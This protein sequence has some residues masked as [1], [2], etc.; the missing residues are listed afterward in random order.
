MTKN[1]KQTAVPKPQ[2]YRNAHPPSV[3]SG[4]VVGWGAKAGWWMNII[5]AAL[6]LLWPVGLRTA[7]LMAKETAPDWPDAPGV[8]ADLAAGFTIIAFVLWLLRSGTVGRALATV[9][10]VVWVLVNLGCYEFALVYE[11]ID[12]LRHA[13]Y[14]LDPTFFWGSAI[15]WK[16]L[17]LFIAS[18]AALGV[19]I[20]WPH[21]VVPT[22]RL[23][24]GLVGIALTGVA[25]S[26]SWSLQ[27]EVAPWRQHNLV[28]ANLATG[29][30][31]ADEHSAMMATLE[32][33]EAAAQ[34]FRRD[35]SGAPV[36]PH[37]AKPV[38]VLL[39]LLEGVSGGYLPSIA[40]RSGFD[41]DIPM[42]HLDTIAQQGISWTS[43]ITHEHQTNRGE[44]SILC[45]DYPKL[46][47][48]QAKMSEYILGSRRRCL[49]RILA[50]AGWHTAYL[51]SAPLAFMY[52]DQF[53]AQIGFEQVYG[54][55]WF[56]QAY[57]RNHWG[58][59]DRAFF[60]QGMYLVRT[61]NT[62]PKPWF[63]TLL[64]VGTHHP[65]IVPDDFKV[66]GEH[67]DDHTRALLWLDQAVGEFYA[68]LVAEGILDN[69]LVL[70]TSDESAGFQHGFSDTIRTLSGNWGI[71]I[72]HSPGAPAM[73]IDDLVVQSDLSLSVLDYLGLADG[74][75]SH[76]VGRSVFRRYQHPRSA[77]FANL[78]KNR[79]YGI[80]QNGVMSTCSQ[81][82]LTQCESFRSTKG[83][84]FAPSY[85]KVPDDPARLEMIRQTV[86]ASGRLTPVGSRIYSL[87]Q[88]REIKVFSGDG[89][90]QVIFGG[91]F[92][93]VEGNMR[94]DVVL[95]VELAG[96]KGSVVLKHF[97]GSVRTGLVHAPWLFN[98]GT[99]QVLS[100]SYTATLTETHHLLQA[101]LSI[102]ES[103]G[104]DLKLRF[105]NAR[106]SI[107]PITAAAPE[108]TTVRVHRADIRRLEE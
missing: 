67:Q 24:A 42:K 43:M 9:V 81:N 104:T 53:M 50:D 76:F 85:Y 70:F 25:L 92:L 69:T 60:E 11:G 16:L 4:S 56:K 52:K 46:D 21:N 93:T 45:G 101:Y 86:A 73:M 62:K 94:I 87:L 61:L 100:F 106:M 68:A 26:T 36:I 72:A 91:Q 41:Y 80:D 33:K 18:S 108:K 47:A 34:L 31:S 84:V 6:I 5:L 40:T 90:K 35:L 32:L 20:W 54:D 107:S 30:R 89:K 102:Q 8:M 22:R 49:P 48:S 64:T 13:H 98:L 63:L 51:Q 97:L 82:Q 28:F 75:G 15:T 17:T 57:A 38:N 39:V 44:Y 58:I 1:T 79:V 19:L 23:V 3:S 59:D 37:V 83:G 74:A 7:L 77:V 103:Q 95:E 105:R 99:N 78:Y 96:S 71:L 27:P 65:Y 29:L 55:T 66:T 14:L 88:P 12:A 10:A 2:N